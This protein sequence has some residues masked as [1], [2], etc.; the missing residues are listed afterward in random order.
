VVFPKNNIDINDQV[1]LIEFPGLKIKK[2]DDNYLYVMVNENKYTLNLNDL[3]KRPRPVLR[4]IIKIM[5]D[6]L[7]LYR[8]GMWQLI[9]KL[10]L[11][12]L[13]LLIN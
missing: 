9:S 4:E 11:K 6:M 12:K 8:G 2:E 1:E 13:P 10:P 3:R 5:R 7:W